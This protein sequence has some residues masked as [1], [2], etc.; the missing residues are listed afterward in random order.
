MVARAFR[1]KDHIGDTEGTK[2]NQHDETHDDENDVFY[3]SVRDLKDLDS[4]QQGDVAISNKDDEDDRCSL[5]KQLGEG[6]KTL[7]DDSGIDE[8]EEYHDSLEKIETAFR[9]GES[10]PEAS[11]NKNTMIAS[12][13]IGQISPVNDEY[14]DAVNNTYKKK[15]DD[16]E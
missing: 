10:V 3:D 11:D 15:K 16:N 8:D 5:K 1:Q 4:N 9:P 7:N 2:E 12:P 14:R 13:T 6:M